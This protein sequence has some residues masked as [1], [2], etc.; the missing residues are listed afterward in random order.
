MLLVL[1]ENNLQAT[2]VIKYEKKLFF[3]IHPGD[4]LPGYEG[5]IIVCFRQRPSI[6]F[7]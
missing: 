4:M 1:I 5:T 2:F 7:K 3:D 6:F